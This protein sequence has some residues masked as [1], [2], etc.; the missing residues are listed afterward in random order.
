MGSEF[1]VGRQLQ[2]LRGGVGA[3]GRGGAY[4]DRTAE[5]PACRR[6]PGAGGAGQ[7]GPVSAGQLLVVVVSELPALPLNRSCTTLRA[8][9][10]AFL[11]GSRWRRSARAP[12]AF[13]PA[14]LARRSC[15]A[16]SAFLAASLARRSLSLLAARW[17]RS[18]WR[19]S[20]IRLA[21]RCTCS[22][23]LR[24]LPAAPSA[25]RCLADLALV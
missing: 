1:Q 25:R 14:S 7:A 5:E 17:P 19:K 13:L 2:P 22:D 10:S 18:L 21:A 24:R 23:A 4:L 8:L 9:S 20:C 3:W 6:P 16:A 12:S 11:T 15:R